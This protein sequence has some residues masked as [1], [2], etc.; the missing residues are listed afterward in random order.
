MPAGVPD[1]AQVIAL[2]PLIVAAALALG[3]LFHFVWP[4]RF[5]PLTEALWFGGV[6][7]RALDLHRAG[8]RVAIGQGEDGAG[9]SQTDNGNSS[10]E[11]YI[12]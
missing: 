8:S 3:L 11:A 6:R 5:L 4:V 7:P 9:C 2:P 12:G 1:K 10:P